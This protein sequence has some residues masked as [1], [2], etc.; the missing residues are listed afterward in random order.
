MVTHRVKGLELK[1]YDLN[2]NEWVDE[3][4][5]DNQLPVTLS[6]TLYVQTDE[7]RTGRLQKYT[8]RIDI[9][10]GPVSRETRRGRRRIQG[11]PE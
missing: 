11:Q 5:R 4:E 1:I 10:L 3:W 2:R 7:S 8:R 6:L 9:P